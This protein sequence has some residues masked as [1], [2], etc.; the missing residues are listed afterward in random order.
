MP[1]Q[2]DGAT[3][4]L[5]LT[6]VTVLAWEQAVSLPMATRLL[7]DL[8]ATVIRLE[9]HTRATRRPRHLANDLV[10]N[11]RSLAVDLRSEQG[12][13]LVRR[14]VRT[15]DVLCENF[16]PRVKRAFGLTYEALR[17]ERHDL[18]ML[19]LTGYGQTGPWAERPTYGPGIESAAG[20]ARTGGY[21]DALP[22]RPGTIVYADNISGFYAGLAILGALH[23]RRLT[24]TGESID[25]AM[26]EA[27]A[28][29]LG[30]S[31]AKSSL[32][33][34]PETRRGNADPAASIQGVFESREHERWLA[35]TVWPG[36]EQAL[37]ELLSAP[38]GSLEAWIR[39]Q[40]A[41]AAAAALQ[42]IGIA[43][44]P[45]LDAHD[46]LLSEQLRRREAF[47]L[48]THEQPVNDCPAHPHAASPWRFAGHPRPPLH[49]AP[50]VGQDSRMVLRRWAGLD[51]EA[52]DRLVA[53]GV[54]GVV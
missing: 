50:A 30:I 25:L 15:V 24:G 36:Q 37:T 40:D 38:L 46:V 28:F 6:G 14:M 44:A 16:T 52:I 13:G 22:T 1:S 53:E 48:I 20:H 41:A 43:A 10:R 23:R 8:G 27:N 2:H 17:E 19:S 42:A 11:K 5:P 7:A 26:Y 33:G 21:P 12:R 39:T 31:I 32:S 49:E 34:Q 51:D 47:S 54:V 9:A 18:I 29:H 35:V 4:L 45:V 3:P